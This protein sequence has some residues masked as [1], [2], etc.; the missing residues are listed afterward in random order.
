MHQRIN[1]DYGQL[2]Y[3]YR[4]LH[5]KYNLPVDRYKRLLDEY[6]TQKK[7][8]KKYRKIFHPDAKSSVVE[9]IISDKR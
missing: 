7:E 9:N 1:D 4:Q 6:S 5:W 3:E 8:T 2:E